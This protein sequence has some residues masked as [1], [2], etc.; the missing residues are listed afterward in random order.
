MDW[1]TMNV[2]MLTEMIHSQV[3]EEVAKRNFSKFI[4][5]LHPSDKR[6]INRWDVRNENNI[7][8][9]QFYCS[10]I[11]EGLLEAFQKLTEKYSG[12]MRLY[13]HDSMICVEIKLKKI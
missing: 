11:G 2:E 6:Y 7:T 3:E 9:L 10:L 5:L 4:G 1:I 13:P 12:S 8:I